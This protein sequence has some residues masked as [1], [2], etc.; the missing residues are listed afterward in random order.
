MNGAKQI[1]IWAIS[2]LV[3]L[4]LLYV[5]R[6]VLA[7]FVA[8]MAVAYFVDPVA[9]KLEEWGLSRTLATT[10]ITLTFFIVAIAGISTVLPILTSQIIGFAGRVPMYFEQLRDVIEPIMHQIS[11]DISDENLKQIVASAQG[12][13]KHALSVLS[14][15][16]NSVISGGAAVIDVVSVLVLT[17]LVTFYL[18]RDWDLL[19]ARIDG[20]LPRNSAPVIREQFIL[21]DETLAGFVRGQASVCLVLGAF[22][23]IGLSLVGLEFGLMVGLGAGFISFVPYVGAM[24]GLSVG[25]CIALVQFGEWMPIFIVVC[26]FLTGQTAESYVL[27]PKLVGERIGLH[28]VWLIFALMA[29][30]SLAGFTGV[31]LAVPIAA[32]IGVLIRFGLAEYLKSALYTGAPSDHP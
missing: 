5:L 12:F 21:I 14:D 16:F 22:Y 13:T 9:D 10:A 27:T 29:G 28:P 2:L 25:L 4:V 17:P 24:I 3:F 15:L 1:R 23:A 31:L 20:W 7:P 32:I 6:D 11:S 26:I 19:V 30:G 8:G 18:L